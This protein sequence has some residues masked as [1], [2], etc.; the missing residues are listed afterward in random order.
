MI[1]MKRGSTAITT[2]ILAAL[3]A[4]FLMPRL[5]EATSLVVSD[6]I[7]AFREELTELRRAGLL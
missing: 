2:L 5:N 7:R 1:L 4:F 3:A 6:S